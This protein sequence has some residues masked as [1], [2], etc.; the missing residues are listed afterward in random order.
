MKPPLRKVTRAG[1]LIHMKGFRPMVSLQLECGHTCFVKQQFSSVRAVRCAK[2][3]QVPD[4]P[5]PI[6][7]N[8]T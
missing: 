1:R 7:F 2:C 3:P 4:S 5:L 6:N 8:P